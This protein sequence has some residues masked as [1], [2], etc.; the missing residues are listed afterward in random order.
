MTTSS[1]TITLHYDENK[2]VIYETN[3]SNAIV[4]SYTWN[5][6]NPVSMTRGGQTYYYQLNG[7][8]DVVALTNST[9]AVINTYE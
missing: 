8:G 9:G 7:H 1:G 4:A 3:S 2:N 6:N 5:G